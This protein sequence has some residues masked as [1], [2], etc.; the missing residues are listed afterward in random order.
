MFVVVKLINVHYHNEDRRL[1]KVQFKT[2]LEGV[3]EE[4]H[5]YIV[6]EDKTEREV[7]KEEGN[8]EYKRLREIDPYMRAL[9]LIDTDKGNN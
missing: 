2:T 4:R 9:I 6:S 5:Y 8:E 3:K 1:T 7:S